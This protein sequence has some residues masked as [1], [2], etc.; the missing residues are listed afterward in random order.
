MYFIVFVHFVGCIKEINTLR[1][2][3]GIESFEEVKR[4]QGNHNPLSFT[5]HNLVE[6]K[7]TKDTGCVTR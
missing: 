3:H 6:H 2:N 1:K 5:A 4:F 7:I